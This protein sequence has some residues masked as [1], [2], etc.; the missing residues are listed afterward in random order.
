VGAGKLRVLATA[1]RRRSLPD[2]PTIAEVVG[3]DY[4]EDV[5]NSAVVPA[6]TPKET[7]A[8]LA[9]WIRSALTTPEVHSKLVAQGFDPAG[10]C[11][12]EFA[13]FLRTQATEYAQV[14]RESNMKAE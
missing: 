13:A 11:G 3:K 12:A 10:T 9:D 4:E 5:W 14:I 6:N 1:A 7:V 8:Q 2:V